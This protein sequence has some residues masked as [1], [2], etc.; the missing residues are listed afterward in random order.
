M[1]VSVRPATA[2]QPRFRYGS[3]GLAIDSDFELSG[4]PP[5]DD[6]FGARQSLTIVRARIADPAVAQREPMIFVNRGHEQLLAWAM[7]GAFRIAADDRIEVDPNTG[8][9]DS[10]IALPL[11]GAVLA[12]LL[13]RRG[14]MVFHASA[15][16]LNGA[17]VILLGDK[18]AGKSTTAGALIGGGHALIA[19]DIAAIDFAAPNGPSVLPAFGQLKLW[20]DSGSSLRDAG[21]TRLGRLHENVDK[22]HYALTDRVS[23]VPVPLDRLYVLCRSKAPAV[24]RLATTDALALLLR[25]SYM[26]R[27][28]DEGFGGALATYFQRAGWLA[29]EGKVR[30]LEVPD[31][32]EAIGQIPALVESD[33]TYP[34]N[35]TQL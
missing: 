19:D 31:S 23:S 26:A 18:G 9:A 11:L 1:N 7:V 17:A 27:F 3:Y 29:S 4:L 24:R 34:L 21:I 35:A 16:A 33:L 10:L 20:D 14:L 25:Y 5:L 22:S 28:G 30:L 12:T 32:L 6:Q 15:V 13:H 8:V 2:E